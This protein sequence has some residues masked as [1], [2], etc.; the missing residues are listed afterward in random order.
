MKP[1]IIYKI[2]F[3]FALYISDFFNTA[4]ESDKSYMI[5]H[6]VYFG[7]KKQSPAGVVR[8]KKSIFKK[9]RA[10]SVLLMY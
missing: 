6:L 2:T 5:D 8:C 7:L 3:V 4:R 10:A 1:N 9:E